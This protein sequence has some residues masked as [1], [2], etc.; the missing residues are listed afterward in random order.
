MTDMECLGNDIII[1]IQASSM[2][3]FTLCH[4]PRMALIMFVFFVCLSE[5]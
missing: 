1:F 2:F 5:C 3:M 4:F